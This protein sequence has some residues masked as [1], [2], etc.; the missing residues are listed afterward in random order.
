MY[1]T[2]NQSYWHAS[3]YYPQYDVL[4]IGG[5]FTGL[6]AGIEILKARPLLKVGILESQIHGTLASSRNAGFMCFGSPTELLADLLMA[7]E[8]EIRHLLKLKNLGYHTLLNNLKGKKGIYKKAKAYELFETSET[9]KFQDVVDKLPHLNALLQ[10]ATGIPNYFAT[11]K[12]PFSNPKF[13][14]IHF[15]HE[16]QIHPAAALEALKARF[17]G[18]GGRFHAGVKATH[19]DHSAHGFSIQTHVELDFD[20]TSLIVANNAFVSQLCPEINVQPKRAQ[21]LVTDSI[22]NLP[23]IGNF[24]M[25]S[26]YVY[27]RNIGDRLLLGGLR[28]TDFQTEETAEP[29]LN[30]SIQAKLTELAARL[31]P[32]QTISISHRWSGIMGFHQ[33][34]TPRMLRNANGAIVVAGMN[35][36]GTLLGPAL[37]KLAASELVKEFNS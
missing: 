21:V 33:E 31:L 6:T 27:F 4:I 28:N 12:S 25:N 11:K 35:G 20:S 9:N 5:G 23:Y 17:L 10:Q 32:H 22:K 13:H 15:A 1:N 26:G 24:H 16:G 19:I 29:D 30:E 14:W 8:V 3:Y 36:M 18:L 37:G 34:G 7:P 2:K